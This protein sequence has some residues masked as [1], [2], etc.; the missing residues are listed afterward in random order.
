VRSK[1][2]DVTQAKKINRVF[3][4]TEQ[5]SK[6][7]HGLIERQFTFTQ[8]SESGHGKLLLSRAMQIYS[9]ETQKSTGL[10][11]TEISE[12]APGTGQNLFSW[13]AF[14]NTIPGVQRAQVR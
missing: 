6:P 13:P 10:N 5:S 7:N 1:A 8:R 14:P 4:E 11:G 3:G 2:A 12:R 9:S